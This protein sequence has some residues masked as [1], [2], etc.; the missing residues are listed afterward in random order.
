MEV[1]KMKN[2]PKTKEE[3]IQFLTELGWS[4]EDSAVEKFMNNAAGME[5]IINHILKTD[6]GDDNT[7]PVTEPSKHVSADDIRQAI[8]EENFQAAK[9]KVANILTSEEFGK[10]LD[11]VNVAGITGQEILQLAESRL[12]PDKLLNLVDSFSEH[13]KAKD[14]DGMSLDDF[15]SVPKSG[16]KDVD[17]QT[18]SADDKKDNLRGFESEEDM[19]KALHVFR[20]FIN[21]EA[22]EK[23]FNE[24]TE[25]IPRGQTLKQIRQDVK[26][27]QLEA[28]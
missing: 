11:T 15:S 21:G 12:D 2:I 6:A 4:T 19:A 27:A 9:K 25:S 18:M 20:K 28:L 23:E 10:Y 7:K 24:Y 13:S 26:V 5:Q 22:S 17:P 8:K 3:A 14:S 16:G 1:A